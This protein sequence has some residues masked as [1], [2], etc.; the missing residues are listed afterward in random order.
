MGGFSRYSTDKKWH[1]P[2]FEKMLYDNAQMVSLYSKAYQL[3]KN[4]TYKNVVFETLEFVKKELTST[5][6][7]FYS[8][9][10]ADS[11]N[12][13]NV[14]EEGAYYYWTKNELKSLIK[15]N[16]DL[17]S[18]YYN[19]NKFG[20]WEK[21]KY[22]LIKSTDDITF[23][24]QNNVLLSDLKKLKVSWKTSLQK[25]QKER[26]KP[27]LDDKILTSWNALMIN[28]YL[29]A[30]IVFNKDEYLDSALKAANFILKNQLTEENKLYHNYKNGKSTINGLLEDYATV[31]DAFIKLYQITSE[32]LWLQ[33]A[34]NIVEY[35]LINFYDKSNNLFN[36]TSKKET[37]LIAK[38]VDY[39]DNVIASS[40][41][42]MAKNLF[43][44]S[45][46][47][48]QKKY[49][50][51]ATSMLNNVKSK[52]ENNG[53]YFSNWLDLMLNYTNP[54]FEVVIVGKNAKLKL[55]ELNK[56]YLPNILISYNQEESNLP[57]L[58]NRFIEGETYI[59]VCV[60]SSCK[61][62]VKTIKESLEFI[63]Y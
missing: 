62:P 38:I 37:S 48:S 55:K 42:I 58:K 5:E 7:V 9:L 60:N 35:T 14:L 31:I 34:N 36:Y 22:V 15:I 24:K 39:E 49:N 56:T 13:D 2:H 4:E 19:I 41:S 17:F 61:M 29:D 54:Y 32:E 11:F 51:I 30:Y 25:H 1:I 43:A 50:N 27:R 20:S 40:N 53:S 28:A 10:D 26:N 57:L 21:D 46:Y 59:Y 8:S 18:K 33:K 23:S 47:L 16:F 63:K 3:T 44:L 45:H 52:I 6:D 12:L